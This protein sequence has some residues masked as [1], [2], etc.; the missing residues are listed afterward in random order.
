LAGDDESA[1]NLGRVYSPK[2]LEKNHPVE[3][4]VIGLTAGAKPSSKR[5][6]DGTLGAEQEPERAHEREFQQPQKLFGNSG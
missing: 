3:K 2:C 1:M 4:V 5:S 6:K